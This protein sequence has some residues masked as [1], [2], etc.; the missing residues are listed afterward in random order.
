M[1][2]ARFIL[3]FPEFAQTDQSFV[4]AKLGEATARMG[5]PD[6]RVW[7]SYSLDSLPPSLTDIAQANLAA[8]YLISSPFG[9]E[10]RLD[11]DGGKSKYFRKWEECMLAVSGGVTVGVGGGSCYPGGWF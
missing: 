7:G 3:F 5:G 8:D 1:S 4:A 6:P 9:T 10:T 11:G 2:P